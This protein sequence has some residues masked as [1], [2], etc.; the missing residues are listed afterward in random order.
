MATGLARAIFPESLGAR[1]SFTLVGMRE[2]ADREWNEEGDHERC[3]V[4][5]TRRGEGGATPCIP[6]LPCVRR[7]AQS[8]VSTL[9]I[10][11]MAANARG[12][13]IGAI[14]AT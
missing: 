8:V 5:G 7:F 13:S 12:I 1:R 2:R 11:R 10:Y 9:L 14:Q 6:F 3:W 4:S